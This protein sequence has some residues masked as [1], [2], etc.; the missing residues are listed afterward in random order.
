VSV[1]VTVQGTDATDHGSLE[2]ERVRIFIHSGRNCHTLTRPE[3]G[4]H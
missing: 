2:Y 4:P 1:F 3:N